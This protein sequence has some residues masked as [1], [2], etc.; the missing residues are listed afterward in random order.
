M[1]KRLIF[2]LDNTLIKWEDFY[3]NGMKKTVEEFKLDVDYHK[4]HE[5]ADNY[6]D[7]YNYY[8][9][10]NLLKL[11]SEKA[12]TNLDMSFVDRW[13]YNLSE[14]TV[15]NDSVIDTLKYLSTKYELVVLTN[16]VSE[17][18]IKRLKK[19]QIYEYFDEVIGGEEFI[20]PSRE[21]FLKAIGDKKVEE[22]I[23]IGDNVDI[24][25]LGAINVGL[26]AILMDPNDKYKDTEYKRIK[27]IRELKE[28]L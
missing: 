3:I 21:S 5:V 11:F 14:L 18:Q 22:C 2:D 20:K 17:L 9:K 13:F 28:M 16:Y 19:A 7:F 8:S 25:I 10:E 15:K 26:D 24:D 12:N 1:K 4:L 27:E 6:E 23:M